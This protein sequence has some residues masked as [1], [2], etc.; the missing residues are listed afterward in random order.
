MPPREGRFYTCDTQMPGDKSQCAA[1]CTA[2]LNAGWAH[3][4]FTEDEQQVMRMEAVC[5][6]RE[7][8]GHLA[9]N[10]GGL[11]DVLE[12]GIHLLGAS[13]AAQVAPGQLR[14]AALA[15]AVGRF[16]QQD[17]AHREH[18]GG[19]HC[20]AQSDTPAPATGQVR[21]GCGKQHHTV[22]HSQDLQLV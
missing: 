9:G 6:C 16:G 22:N 14:D 7:V 17:A 2:G 18:D 8:D 20:Q 15:E 5:N 4:I 10:A 12:L 13:D 21:H 3:P 11:L 1:T 19:E